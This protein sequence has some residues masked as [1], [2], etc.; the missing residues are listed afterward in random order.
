MA[1]LETGERGLEG[2]RNVFQVG[3][4]ARVS[5]VARNG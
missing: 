5:S 4:A 1:S 2:G 3:K